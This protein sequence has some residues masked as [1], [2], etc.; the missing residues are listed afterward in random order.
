LKKKNNSERRFQTKRAAEQKKSGRRG[1]IAQRE[2]SVYMYKVNQ[3]AMSSF[4][5]RILKR[6]P[7]NPGEMPH[8]GKKCAKEGV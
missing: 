2:N 1:P 5:S 4:S 3:N 8:T 6:P 7:I